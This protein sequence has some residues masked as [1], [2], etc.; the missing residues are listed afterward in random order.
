M[1]SR[2]SQILQKCHVFNFSESYSY[3]D[4]VRKAIFED[5]FLIDPIDIASDLD[6][7]ISRPQKW[8][9]LHD[10]ID[11]VVRDDLN[12]YFR[13]GGWDYEDVNPVFSMLEAHNIEYTTLEQYIEEHYRDDE[14]GKTIVVTE[15]HIEQYK[16]EYAIEYLEDIV[17]N[18][19]PSLIVPEVFTLLFSDRE[20]MK[21]FN[22]K[23]AGI[24]GT[25]TARCTY[26]P[27]WLERAL[28]CREKGLCAICKS[29]LTSLHHVNGKLAIDHIIPIALNG[30]NDP[31]NLQIL[32]EA[33]NGKKSG[34]EVVT[35]NALP[36]FW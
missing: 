10:Y 27:K 30:V 31:T 29:D 25:R 14:T 15:D 19:L 22:L 11:Y 18:N 17:L 23:I 3:A 24:L 12:F 1:E 8:S 35:S 5:N 2:M 36:V 32:C 13:G 26:W 21:A 34:H 4:K 28:F 20:A 9:L 33:C 7:Q 16:Y 6:N